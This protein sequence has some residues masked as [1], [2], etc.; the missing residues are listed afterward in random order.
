MDLKEISREDRASVEPG[1][2]KRSLLKIKS[3]DA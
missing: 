3:K 1:N 2:W